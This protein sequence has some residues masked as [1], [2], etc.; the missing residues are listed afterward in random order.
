MHTYHLAID[1]GAS[2]G[3]HILGWREEGTVRTEELY[4]FSNGVLESDGHLTWDIAHLEREV[5]T[6]ID[7]ALA[8]FPNDTE[9]LYRYLG[10]RLCA[11]SGRGTRPACLCLPG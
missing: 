4:R 9:S 2:S 3:R 1:I 5:R 8:R 11:P 10:S 6:G 7:A